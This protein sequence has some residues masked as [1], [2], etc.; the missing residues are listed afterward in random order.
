MQLKFYRVGAEHRGDDGRGRD[1]LADGDRTTADVAGVGRE[2][3]GVRHGLLRDGYS[4]A[5]GFD[6]RLCALYG[7]IVLARGVDCGFELLA[8]VVDLRARRVALRSVLIVD[9]HRHVARLHKLAVALLV[10]FGQA[11]IGLGL[12]EARAGGAH[13]RDGARVEVAARPESDASLGLTDSGEGLRDA[14]LRLCETQTRVAVVEA[15]DCL[16]LTDECAH[17]DRRRDDLPR[18]LRRNVR[19]LFGYQTTRGLYVRGDFARDRRGRRDGDRWSFGLRP[20]AAAPSAFRSVAASRVRL[21]LRAPARCGE[22]RGREQGRGER[23]SARAR[24]FRKRYR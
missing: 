11:Q 6:L 4:R 19:C 10:G 9:A 23:S 2:H 15:R 20:R 14:R 22:E 13:F 21:R 18:C 5:G 12:F 8:H 7:L 24:D 1:V 16:A 3:N 17:V